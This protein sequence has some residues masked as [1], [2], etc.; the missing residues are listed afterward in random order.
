MQ[1]SR[2]FLGKEP[3]PRLDTPDLATRVFLQNV[4]LVPQGPML[5][6]IPSIKTH[7]FVEVRRG[8]EEG[9]VSE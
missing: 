9:P 3:R 4:S 1:M 8:I 7:E 5:S 2:L 6:R